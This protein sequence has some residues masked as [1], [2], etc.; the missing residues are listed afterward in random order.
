MSFDF[1]GA[2]AGADLEAH[3]DVIQASA[4][5][6]GII[7]LIVSLA[8]ALIPVTRDSF[9]PA[10]LTAFLFWTSISV[11]SI[12]LC[13]L[14]QLVGGSWAL[15]L[16]RPFEAAGAMIV[17]MALFFLP[18]LVG[19]R[20]GYAF[21][22]AD[23][24]VVQADPLVA[25]KTKFLNFPFFAARGVFYFA[26]WGL[27]AYLANAWSRQQDGRSDTA[28][29]RRLKAVAGPALVVLFLSTS[30]AAFDW[31][32][33]RDPDWYSTIY[34]AMFIV[35]AILSTLAFATVFTIRNSAYEPIRS[36][37]TVGRL[38][39]VGNL[40]LAFTMLWAY[41][42]FSQ[43]LITWLGN[44][45]EEVIWYL[46]RIGG[47][48]G[49]VALGLIAFGFFAPFLA[50]LERQ[51]KR[52]AGW[53]LPIA[54]WIL[55]MRAVDLAW[56]IL[57]GY[58]KIGEGGTGFPWLGVLWYAAALAGIGGVWLSFFVRRLRTAPLIPLQDPRIVEALA[59]DHAHEH[60][61]GA[62]L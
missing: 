1:A 28:P 59:H 10:Y 23:A 58:A 16:R 7:G 46:R 21:P 14:H 38:N 36:A 15:P 29:S 48:W 2:R 50:L 32:M 12:G 60:S 8:G 3:F 33:S 9:F 25:H 19:V 49:V 41:M 18:I 31:G 37:L 5:R 17:L 20:L 61:G 22:W 42:S 39:D 57:P 4:L 52:D 47:V 51:H 27:A 55:V 45:P 34:G 26:V 40:L 6:V 35:G 62:V 30:F 43:F 54:S 11:A 56:L 13:F 53:V 24:A 44:L